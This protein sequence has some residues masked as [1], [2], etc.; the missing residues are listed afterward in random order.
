LSGEIH[1]AN[2]PGIQFTQQIHVNSYGYGDDRELATLVGEATNGFSI[3]EF[4][5]LKRLVVRDNSGTRPNEQVE[6]IELEPVRETGMKECG[7]ES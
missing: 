3:D 6:A 1:A 5:R 4:R 2:A 7:F